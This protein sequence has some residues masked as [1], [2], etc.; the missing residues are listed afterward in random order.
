MRNS[1]TLEIIDNKTLPLYNHHYYDYY[2]YYYYDY[3][4]IYYNTPTIW[5]IGCRAGGGEVRPQDSS[6]SCEDLASL[7]VSLRKNCRPW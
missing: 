4:Y 2:Y 3:F 6:S 7:H 5:L 1:R